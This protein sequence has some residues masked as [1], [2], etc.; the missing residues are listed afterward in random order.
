MYIRRYSKLNATT[1]V[2][3]WQPPSCFAANLVYLEMNPSRCR[4]HSRWK[5]ENTKRYEVDQAP[6]G[7]ECVIYKGKCG[8]E[9][10]ENNAIVYRVYAKWIGDK[11]VVVPISN[12]S[13][14]ACLSTS[15]GLPF[16]VWNLF[17]SLPNTYT[18]FVCSLIQSCP[19]RVYRITCRH[20]NQLMGVL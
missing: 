10:T 20:P 6:L 11:K 2:C 1:S 15:C 18:H 13:H 12:G 14:G 4:S 9:G 3:G 8:V 5:L 16:Y 19:R 7:W 17:P